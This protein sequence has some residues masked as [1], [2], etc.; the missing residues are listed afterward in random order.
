M[1]KDVWEMYFVF[2]KKFALNFVLCN[3]CL[4]SLPWRV[5]LLGMGSSPEVG[6]LGLAAREDPPH[7]GKQDLASCPW[8]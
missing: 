8:P 3:R 1:G 2:S 6:L 7:W 4:D 5:E